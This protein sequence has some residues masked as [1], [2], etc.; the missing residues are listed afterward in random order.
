MFNPSDIQRFRE[1]TPGVSQVIHLN[2]AGAALPPEPVRRAM[3][4]YLEEEMTLGGYETH[5]KYFSQIEGV[6]ESVAR[7]INAQADEIAMLEN[8]TVAWNQVFQAIDFKAGDI[9]ITSRADYASNYLSYLHLQRK[10]AIEIQVIPNDEFDQPD[11]EALKSMMNERVR[12]VAITHIPTNGGLVAP[13]EEIGAIVKQYDALYLLDACQSA[14]QYPLDVEKIGCDMLSATG[15]K[16][17]R[18]PRG[19][20]FLYVSKGV[21]SKLTPNW[22]DLHSAEWTGADQYKIRT[23]ARKFENWEGN[24]AGTMGLKAAV[25]YINEIGIDSI[26]QRILMLGQKLREKMIGVKGVTVHD[27]GQLKCGIVSFTVD[28]KSAEEVKQLLHKQ[29]INVSWNGTSNT[30]LD[31]SARQL[32]EIIRASVH[33]YN[34]EGEIDQ[35]IATLNEVVNM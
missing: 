21:N 15:R 22:V 23:D 18:G 19:T 27:L 11:L 14:G 16:Y 35:F 4:D 29:G 1:E 25:D 9:V 17:L 6:Y 28:G 26:W 20:G 10:V 24:R 8:A 2:N 5:T 31:M 30:F 3:I 32:P 33:Y 7:L 13:A 12:L 34:T